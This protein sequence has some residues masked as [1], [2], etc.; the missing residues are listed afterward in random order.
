M[1]NSMKGRWDDSR[2]VRH[3]IN[4]IRFA[5]VFS[6]PPTNPGSNFI[7][8]PKNSHSELTQIDSQILGPGE[9]IPIEAFYHH[10]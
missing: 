4:K 8:G 5:S 3:L 10:G 1:E 7:A 2:L 9:N 6:F